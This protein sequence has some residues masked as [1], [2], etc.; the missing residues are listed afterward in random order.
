MASKLRVKPRARKAVHGGDVWA[1]FPVV[2]FSSNVNPIGPP[3][4][5]L[6]GLKEGLWRIKYYPDISG[7]EL[8]QCLAGHLGISP[9]NIALGNGSTELI[10]NF[11]EAFVEP[12]D[13]VVIAEPTFSEYAVWCEWRD[14]RV[15]RV[16][17]DSSRGFRVDVEELANTQAD[18]VFICN[19]NNPTGVFTDDIRILLEETGGHTLVFLDE[20]YI[21]FTASES[22]RNLVEEYPNLCVLRSMTKFYSLPGL[23]MGYAVANEHLIRALEGVSVPWNINT[24]AEVAAISALKDEE[25]AKT[26]R[27]YIE[28]EKASLLEGLRKLGVR[29]YPSSANF[30]LL[31]LRDFGI[32]AGELRGKLLKKGLLIRD[33]SSFHGLDEYYARVA[34]GKG[35]DN[36][37]LLDEM[38]GIL[39]E[40]RV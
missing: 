15:K 24:M 1:H 26:S 25:F 34:A 22:A 11:C 2:D 10:K 5:V 27:G 13:E 40:D 37:R 18:V 36:T 21:D 29:V 23:R 30:F 3:E 20:A 17:A 39:A 31:D 4:S 7:R 9:G 14:A 32:T 28:R 35:E 33:C 38:R 12:D 8:K 16:Y 6:Q 19:P